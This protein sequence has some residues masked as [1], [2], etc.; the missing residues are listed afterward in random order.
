MQLKLISTRSARVLATYADRLSNFS[1]NARFYLA[2]VILSGAAMGIYR[3]LFNF[4]ILSQGYDEALLGM[5]V[6]TSSMTALIVALPMGFLAD[7]LGRRI[8]LIAGTS[9]VALAVALVVLFPSVTVF[10]GA[11][12]LMGLAQSL[13]GVTMGPFLMENS[14][15]KER[16]YLFSFSS[17][18]SMASAFVGN[19]LGGYLPTWMS[20]MNGADPTSTASYG[21]ALM[22]TALCGLLAVLPLL[23]LRARKS[24]A[25]RSRI[26]P[27]SEIRA[28]AGP[29]TRL[30]LPTLITSIG[31]GMFMPFMNV[32]FRTVHH[33]PDPVIGSLFAWGSLAMGLGLM[34]A[35]P[36]AERFGKIE[37]IV[38]TQ[39]VSIPFLA[40][41]GFV[42]WFGLCA[43]AYYIRLALM[44]MSGPVYQAFVMEEVEPGSRATVASLASMAGSFGWAFSP[45]ISGWIQV[46]YGFGPAFAIT[47][48]LYTLSTYLYWKF[49]WRR[50]AAAP[51]AQP[52]TV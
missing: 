12:L 42:P 52:R 33:Q 4:Y 43:G 2:S 20:R 13:A 26:A 34:I 49:F 11:N 37:L 10:I 47:M 3:L 19:W 23:F 7:R 32:Y 46:N 1:P 36:L 14:E 9:L 24:G 40:V 25:P 45:T 8:S 27:M 48:V 50:G 51:A 31:A 30:I 28:Q 21:A 16:T 6:T 22:V 35:P 15:E 44:N 38:V 41:L 29:I 17:G 39:A 5:L 18:L